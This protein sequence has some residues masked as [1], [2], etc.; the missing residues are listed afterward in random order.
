MEQERLK[1]EKERQRVELEEQLNQEWDKLMAELA[2]KEERL[3]KERA[4]H[5][6]LEAAIRKNLEES[7][8]AEQ[9]EAALKEQ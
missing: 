1:A 4:L 8:K 7:A 6:K 3:A 2:E 9:N 5:Q